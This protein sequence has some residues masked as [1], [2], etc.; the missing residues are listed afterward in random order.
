MIMFPRMIDRNTLHSNT[1]HPPFSFPCFLCTHQ[2]NKHTNKHTKYLIQHTG[3]T[4]RTIRERDTGT[5]TCTRILLGLL[6]AV[7]VAVGVAVGGGLLGR[8][9]HAHGPQEAQVHVR[10]LARPLVRHAGL[11]TL[12]P[13][14]A[15]TQ[16]KK[17]TWWWWW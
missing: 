11:V 14:P 6:L 2:P 4:G 12:R 15:R 10:L 9:D 3:Y 17:K 8:V 7:G 13:A 1:W 16:M 5:Y